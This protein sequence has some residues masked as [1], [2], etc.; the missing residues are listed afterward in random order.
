MAIAHG[1]PPTEDPGVERRAGQVVIAHAA[2]VGEL[3]A[4]PDREVGA[5]AV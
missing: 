3:S 2:L 4:Q 5:E 1:D